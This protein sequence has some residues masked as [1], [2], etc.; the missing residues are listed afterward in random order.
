MADPLLIVIDLDETLVYASETPLSRPADFSVFSY[1][2]YKRPNVDSFLSNL[3]SRYKVAVW[4]SSGNL[5]AE[6][7]IKAIFPDPSLLAFVWD[8][9]RCTRAYDPEYMFGH[10]IK[11]LKKVFRMGYK[12]ERV[13]MIDDSPEKIIRQYGNFLRVNP[14]KGDLEDRELLLLLRYLE[15]LDREENVRTVEKRGWQSKLD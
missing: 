14:W 11:D 4:T 10:P 15:I 5:Y 3:V 8:S 7:V 2:I 6:G 12:M 1:F 9:R 13:V